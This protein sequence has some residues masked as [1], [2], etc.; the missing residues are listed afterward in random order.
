MMKG[1]VGICNINIYIIILFVNRLTKLV[2][3]VLFVTSEDLPI[4]KHWRSALRKD[5]RTHLLTNSK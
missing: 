3:D 1:N 5:Y 4:L 2:R